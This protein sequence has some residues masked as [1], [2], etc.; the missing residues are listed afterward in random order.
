MVTM[1]KDPLETLIHILSQRAIDLGR[2]DVAWAFESPQTKG[3]IVS[4]V[5]EYLSPVTLLSKEELWL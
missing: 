5:N 3:A 2:D 1:R 4:Y